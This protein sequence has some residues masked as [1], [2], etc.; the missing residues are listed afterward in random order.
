MTVIQ[1][2]IVPLGL[3]ALLALGGCHAA[4]QTASPDEPGPPSA[5]AAGGQAIP[6]A[7][8]DAAT[9]IPTNAAAGSGERVDACALLTHREL[10]RILGPAV[11]PGSDTSADPTSACAFTANGVVTIVVD[12]AGRNQFD[13]DC[14]SEASSANTQAVSGLADGACLTVVGGAIG[15]IYVLKGPDV[16]SINIQAGA[17]AAITPHLLVALGTSAAAR[18]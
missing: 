5:S 8:P 18:L 6:H 2:C 4:A 13:L 10:A 1:K 7:A 9:A 3:A 16:M 14:G 12:P 15:A 17:D 11:G